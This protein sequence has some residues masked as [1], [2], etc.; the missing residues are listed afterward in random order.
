LVAERFSIFA[1]RRL[2][3]RQAAVQGGEDRVVVTERTFVHPLL[4]Q[5]PHDGVEASYSSVKWARRPLAA[6][7]SSRVHLSVDHQRLADCVV[8]P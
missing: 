5:H 7:G 4:E 3:P 2:V 1:F 6:I 8:A